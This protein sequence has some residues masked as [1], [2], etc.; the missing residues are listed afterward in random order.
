MVFDIK[1]D[2]TRKSRVVSGGHQTEVPKESVYSSVVSCDSVRLALMLA[3]L[4]GLS[5]LSAE[6]QNAYL[7]APTKEKCYCITGPEF[8][9][10]KVG[11]PV[12]IVQALYGLRSS[13]ARWMDHLA[14]TIRTMRFRACLADP[15][16]WM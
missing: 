5:V 7:N 9:Q 10:D 3:T 6:V 2:L 15:D 1:A 8:G 12:L 16:V 14:E 13:G 4:N 11:R